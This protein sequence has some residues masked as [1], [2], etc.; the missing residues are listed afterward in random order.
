MK[1][2]KKDWIAAKLEN[3]FFP[4]PCVYILATIF[5]AVYNRPFEFPV[6]TRS[7]QTRVHCENI[8]LSSRNGGR[9]V[10]ICIF[11]VHFY[12]PRE[13]NV[14]EKKKKKRNDQ[15]SRT[16]LLDLLPLDQ[17]HHPRR[18][19]ASGIRARIVYPIIRCLFA[20]KLSSREERGREKERE[21]K[22]T[23]KYISL[24]GNIPGSL[25][26]RIKWQL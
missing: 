20:R 19:I 18:R 5:Y 3:F 7:L 12:R 4:I 2:K 10:C 21:K 11:F 8:F 23:A 9:D 13:L 24:Y 26:S 22:N 1:K 6:D 15:P 17:F 16:P 14:G 25:V